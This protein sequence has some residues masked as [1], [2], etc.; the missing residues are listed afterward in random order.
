MGFTHLHLHSEYSLLDG[1]CKIN[2][3]TKRAAELG[4]SSLAITD[5]GV[6]FG[7]VDFYK[8]AKAAGIKPII[9]CEVY[10]A[11]RNLDQKEK[12]LDTERYHLV[13][14]CKNETGYK[15][16]IKMV[17]KAGKKASM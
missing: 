13:L 4:Q 6:M 8:K 17:L 14:L 1:A 10:V 3:V 16:L 5:H 2:E 15:N 12:G 7:A 9:G 11:A